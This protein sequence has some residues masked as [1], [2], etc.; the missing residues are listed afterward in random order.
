MKGFYLTVEP[1]SD[2]LPNTVHVIVKLPPQFETLYPYI[3]FY[4]PV[5]GPVYSWYE[6]NGVWFVRIPA[7]YPLKDLYAVI[8]DNPVLDGNMVGVS[9]YIDPKYD[10]G[11]KVF[12]LYTNFQFDNPEIDKWIVEKPGFQRRDSENKPTSLALDQSALDKSDKWLNAP[13]IAT[14]Q[15]TEYNQVVEISTKYQLSISNEDIL[16]TFLFQVSMWDNKD[17]GGIT[18]QQISS[19]YDSTV[20][21]MQ[22]GK[23]IKVLPNTF[24]APVFNEPP[25][26]YIT[27]FFLENSIFAGYSTSIEMIKTTPLANMIKFTLEYEMPYRETPAISGSIFRYSLGR[28]T[29]NQWKPTDFINTYWIRVRGTLPNGTPK[30]KLQMQLEKEKIPIA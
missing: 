7:D 6:G 16:P 1:T 28:I 27:I 17:G 12:N 30:A 4:H 21:I 9:P 26:T 20:Y 11:A 22:N 2:R 25:Y 14:Q 19:K 13:T 23:Y 3:K 5:A 24:I 10:N 29:Y 8:H 15:S 18:V